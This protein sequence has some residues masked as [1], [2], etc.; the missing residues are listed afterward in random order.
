[1]THQDGHYLL[2]RVKEVSSDP[3]GAAFEA[4]LNHAAS[5]SAYASKRRFL[6]ER[7]NNR[8]C[9]TTK[10]V[11]APREVTCSAPL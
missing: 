2:L 5:E 3:A 6:A 9:G 10:N 8:V 7:C 1:M 4:R 11:G